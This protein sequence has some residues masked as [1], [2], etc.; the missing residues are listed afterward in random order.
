MHAVASSRSVLSFYPCVS[1]ACDRWCIFRRILAGTMSSRTMLRAFIARSPEAQVECIGD[2]NERRERWILDAVISS[3]RCPL[4]RYGAPSAEVTA[5]WE[6]VENTS[7][8]WST[9][10]SLR[11]TEAV[12]RQEPTVSSAKSYV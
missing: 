5:A 7:N 3:E 2:R 6:L 8:P 9:G 4:R 12:G 11:S 1:E 10:I